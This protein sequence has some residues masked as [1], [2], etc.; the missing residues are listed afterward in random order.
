[1]PLLDWLVCRFA[2]RIE[3]NDNDTIK[4]IKNRS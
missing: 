4:E 2:Q 3:E 1:M